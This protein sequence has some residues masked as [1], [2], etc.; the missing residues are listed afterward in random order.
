MTV[1]YRALLLGRRGLGV[2]LSERSWSDGVKYL[3]QAENDAR[4]RSLF[5]ELGEEAS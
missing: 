5:D 1:P 3:E 2:E 4:A